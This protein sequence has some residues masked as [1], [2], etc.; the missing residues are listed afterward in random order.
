MLKAVLRKVP[1]KEKE[2]QFLEV[3]R[4]LGVNG[5]SLGIRSW[6]HTVFWDRPGV[7]APRS[8]IR[9]RR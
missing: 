8:G 6:N 5:Y 4:G 1:S 9:T 7:F 2:K 3:R